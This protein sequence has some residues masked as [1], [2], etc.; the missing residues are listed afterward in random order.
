MQLDPKDKET[1]EWLTIAKRDLEAGKILFSNPDLTAQA[2]F[3]AQ[4]AAEKVL[5]AFLV[6][7]QERFKKEHDIRYLG[8]MVLQK[9][10]SLDAV[11]DAAVELNPYAVTIRYPGCFTDLTSDEASN[12][13]AIAES[14]YR[15]VLSKLPKNIHP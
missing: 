1:K 14:L 8:G 5:K 9:E 6:W 15:A 4:Q 13:L 12:A 3:F 7:H 10:P 2:S 11:I